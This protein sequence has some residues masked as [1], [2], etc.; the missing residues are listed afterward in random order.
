[1]ARDLEL[2]KATKR[3]YYFKNKEKTLAYAKK[4]REDNNWSERYRFKQALKSS[5]FNSKR[6]GYLPCLATEEEIKAV[7]T[8]NC[9]ACGVSEVEC[10]ER[11][12]MD[13]CHTTGRFRGWLCSNCNSAV[14]YLRESIEIGHKLIDYMARTR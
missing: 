8:G 13:H 3:A 10:H 5:K 11:L 7:F 9:H 1:M 12:H 6:R 4:W 14:G 2:L